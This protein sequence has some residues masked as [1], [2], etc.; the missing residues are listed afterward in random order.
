METLL[1]QQERAGEGGEVSYYAIMAPCIHTRA[2]M[3]IIKNPR[4]IRG[5]S[6]GLT[7]GGYHGED[8]MGTPP[9]HRGGGM[10]NK[11]WST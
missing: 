8:T 1:M 4:G 10:D 9:M 3:Y 11:S 7:T 6:T 5:H 2:R